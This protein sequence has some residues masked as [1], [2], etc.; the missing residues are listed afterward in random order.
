[1]LLLAL[2]DGIRESK[3]QGT[4]MQI[5]DIGPD[6]TFPA[7]IDFRI[8]DAG[9]AASRSYIEQGSGTADDPFVSQMISMLP[10]GILWQ[11]TK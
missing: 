8:D 4:P 6:A 10:A 2:A 3:E 9:V 1:S 5:P 11:V 7:W